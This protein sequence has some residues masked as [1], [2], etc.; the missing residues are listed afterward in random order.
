MYSANRSSK[1]FISGVETSA[2]AP[3]GG[4]VPPGPR[5]RPRAVLLRRRVWT[6]CRARPPRGVGTPRAPD[7]GLGADRRPPVR[8]RE[9]FGRDR[10][11]PDGFEFRGRPI[12]R[13]LGCRRA[14]GAAADVVAKLPQIPEHGCRAERTDG[15]SLRN[16]GRL[17]GEHAGGQ[18]GYSEL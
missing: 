15:Q 13:P 5:R 3:R 2:M 17:T 18:G 10:V 12:D 4:G 8:D 9:R 16:I 14:G 1:L 7:T 6:G 11:N